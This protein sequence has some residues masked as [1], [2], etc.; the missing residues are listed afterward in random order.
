MKKF[1]YSCFFVLLILVLSACSSE[2]KTSTDETDTSVD[3]DI[4]T[5]ETDTSVD[6]D[7]STDEADTSVD[8]DI[9][10]DNI[11]SPNTD[12][13]TADGDD[14]V[15]L[16]TAQKLVMTQEI[17]SNLEI[18]GYTILA[19]PQWFIDALDAYYGDPST[20]PTK[21]VEIFAMSGVAAEVVISNE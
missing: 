12:I 16:S 4:S 21:V 8:A 18:K 7:I 17:I 20:N 19:E 1:Y 2:D 15:Q 14:W 10:T 11:S 13:S 5:D 9:S 3:A 6:A